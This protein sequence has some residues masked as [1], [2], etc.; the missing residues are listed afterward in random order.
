MHFETRSFKYFISAFIFI[1][2]ISFAQLKGATLEV[3]PDELPKGATWDDPYVQVLKYTFGANGTAGGGTWQDND[4]ITFSLPSGVYI[5]NLDSSAL[6]PDS[7]Y[8]D[9]VYISIDGDQIDEAT[10][11]GIA[12]NNDDRTE[13]T[14]IL[15]NGSNLLAN[16][17]F[18]LAFP[19]ITDN[20]ASNASYTAAN[21]DTREADATANI[22]FPS[23]I[24]WD[25]ITFHA[26]YSGNDDETSDLGEVYPAA[27]SNVVTGGL[28]DLFPEGSDA[29]FNGDALDNR[30]GATASAWGG[31]DTNLDNSNNDGEVTYSIWASQD[32]TLNYVDETNGIQLGRAD[33]LAISDN[34]ET[35]G[36][37]HQWDFTA[38]SEGNWI[39]YIESS[40]TDNWILAKSDTIEVKH[41][42]VFGDGINIDNN[43]V[44]GIDYDE[45]GL[46][47]PL[48]DDDLVTVTG[49]AK[50]Y[51]DGSSSASA[52]LGKNGSLDGNPSDDIEFFIELND[53]DDIAT[54]QLFRALVSD[55][56][57]TDIITSGTPGSL[58][59]DSLKGA[60]EIT[61]SPLNEE[62]VY[63]TFL[64]DVARS[65]SD[66]DPANVYYIYAIANDGTNQTLQKFSNSDGNDFKLE[67]LYF[68]SF[69]FQDHY[70][71]NK[72]F[73]TSDEEY[74]VINWG[75]TV[76]GDKDL[77]ANGAMTIDLY[78][79][80]RTWAQAGGANAADNVDPDDLPNDSLANPTETVHITTIVDSIDTRASNRY[81]WNVRESGLDPGT[82]YIYA[83][84]TS[85]TDNAVVALC[86]DGNQTMGDPNGNARTLTLTHGTYFL[87][88][89]PISGEVVSLRKSDSY[90]LKWDAFD[91]DATPSDLIVAAFMIP[92][93]ED[94]YN[95]LDLLDATGNNIIGYDEIKT[96][97]DTDLLPADD[98]TNWYWLTNDRLNGN[99]DQIIDED[100]APVFTNKRY[101]VDVSNLAEDM[102]GASV[103]PFGTYQVYYL[104][105]DDGD[106]DDGVADDD[107]VTIKA[108]GKLNFTGA[109]DISSNYNFRV[110]PNKVVAAKDDTLQFYVIG[111]DP[112]A[113]S[114]VKWLEFFLN[115]PSENFYVVNDTVEEFTGNGVSGS[116]Y[117][118]TVFDANATTENDTIKLNFR[119]YIASAL[120][121]GSN[122]VDVDGDTIAYF[123]LVVKNNAIGDVFDE[124]IIEFNSEGNRMTHMRDDNWEVVGRDVPEVATSITLVPNGTITG[125][126]DLQAVADSGQTVNLFVCPVGSYDCISDSAFLVSNDTNNDASDGVQTTLGINGKYTL[127]QIPLGYYDIICMKDSWLN[128]RVTQ[129]EVQAYATTRVDFFSNQLRAGDCAGYDHDG[130]SG[131]STYSQPNNQI[132]SDDISAMMAAFEST[133]ED[134]NFN[135]YCDITGDELINLSDLYWSA[136]NITVDGGNG[137]GNGLGLI[138]SEKAMAEETSPIVRLL[139][140]EETQSQITY[141]LNIENYSYLHSYAAELQYSA[142]DYTLLYW[143]DFLQGNSTLTFDRDKKSGSTLVRATI[144]N[145]VEENSNSTLLTFTL[146]KNTTSADNPSIK[147]LTLIDVFGNEIAPKVITDVEEQTQPVPVKFGL[148]QNYPNPFNPVTNL[149]FDLPKQADI[150]LTVY[151]ILGR[152]VKTLIKGKLEAG[153]H[154]IQWNGRNEQDNQVSSGMYFY[155]LHTKEF[156]A[157]KKMLLMR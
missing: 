84:I 44:A 9:E 76:D 22:T 65:S 25:D 69:S 98:L 29:N 77:D 17:F 125:F 81:M 73:D 58:T 119:S 78:A 12:Q 71:A 5:A 37:N 106:W 96:A 90:Y 21:A 68:P 27:V 134:S 89:Y 85:G 39:I 95:K 118:G 33:Q 108:A 148:R 109:P 150:R 97:Q 114:N 13:I 138:Y 55:L 10:E 50:L 126:V 32:A 92:D 87:P 115:I 145:Q 107:A 99:S 82:Y 133:S 61:S 67:V 79:S 26:N 129:K 52:G 7:C 64:Y 135:A 105:T 123:Q 4:R 142:S 56:D 112:G 54:V 40:L 94:E 42:P 38:L 122:G 80:Q 120:N 36:L 30:A 83:L 110:E 45:D 141:S 153:T 14:V 31:L 144:G 130:D 124:N 34:N 53:V 15:K 43:Y 127:T 121:Q 41:Y 51:L 16:D 11:I 49:N 24:S 75:A 66:Y 155:E 102:E 48:A 149:Q 70:G 62:A 8:H 116:D 154:I 72:T 23:Q 139:K 59:L 88:K 93:D 151:D 60:W 28:P 46:F 47:E 146:K 104:Y 35:D 137:Q 140:V 157:V 152:K 132:N 131:D 103:E 3:Y 57:A 128:G 156:H 91:K 20:D 1:F 18:V 111:K 2:F 113:S 147:K 136:L 143:N 6:S 19:V 100:D 74:F 117:D 86:S 101:V 63:T